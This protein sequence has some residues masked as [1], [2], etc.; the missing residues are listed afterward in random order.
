MTHSYVGHDSFI[1]V[2]W[3]IHMC[4]MTHSDVW[5]DSFICATWLLHMCDMTHSS[6]WHDSIVCM[7]WLI[8]TCDI[9]HL[10][11]ARFDEVLRI[12]RHTAASAHDLQLRLAA[13]TGL[14]DLL[15]ATPTH[16][17]TLH[18]TA[19][20]C[21]CT[22]LPSEVTP[23][24]G[25]TD[26]TPHLSTVFITEKPYHQ[27]TLNRQHLRNAWCFVFCLNP[28]LSHPKPEHPI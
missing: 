12:L 11:C 22:S 19:T 24:A 21:N 14:S 20:H 9:L 15:Q 10:Q 25:N 7:T 23:P 3:L 8:H 1:C 4:D 28:K 26:T 16:C 6:T 13:L 2:P 5:H 17:N 18:L 27:S